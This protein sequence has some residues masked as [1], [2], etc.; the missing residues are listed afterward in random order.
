M[1]TFYKGG[2]VV[3][4]FLWILSKGT[5]IDDRVIRIVVDV[6][7]RCKDPIDSECPGLLRGGPAELLRSR[8]V[9]GRAVGH[10]VGKRWRFCDS[11]R[12]AALEIRRHQQRRL[13][14]P[15]H[16]I[17]EG[18]HFKR[19]RTDHISIA[20]APGNDE[21]ADPVAHNPLEE[22]LELGIIGGRPVAVPSYYK[23]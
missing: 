19:L 23:H 1:R 10:H 22:S 4:D 13:R 9:M 6:R 11:G 12:G 17:N 18:R 15:L 3:S 5:N 14:K 21:S 8:E 2:H 7:V 16:M 20:N